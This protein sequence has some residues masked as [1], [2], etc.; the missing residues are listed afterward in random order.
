M[1]EERIDRIFQ[2]VAKS[3]SFERRFFKKLSETDNPYPWFEQLS[4]R[5]YLQPCNNRNPETTESNQYVVPYWQVLGY[6]ENAAKHLNSEPNDE[7]ASKLVDVINSILEYKDGNGNRIENPHTDWMIIK[8]VFKLP[9]KYVT[10]KQVK[11]IETAIESKWSNIT[12]ISA[13]IEQTVFP[14]LIRNDHGKFLLELLRIVIR[15]QKKRAGSLFHK[16]SII[17]EYWFSEAMKKNREDIVRICGLEAAKVT[18]NQIEAILEESDSYFS[19]ASIPAIEDN[20]QTMFPDEYECQL[21]YLV[22]DVLEQTSPDL[23]KD[24]LNELLVSQ[25]AIL[26]RIGIHTINNHYQTFSPLFWSWRGNPLEE[27][28]LIHEIFE[29][30]ESRFKY[31]SD[32][33]FTKLI[34]WIESLSYK[35][36]NTSHKDPEEVKRFEARARRRWLTAVLNSKKT[37]IRQLYEKYTQIDDTRIEH[38]SFLVWSSGVVIST[39]EVKPFPKEV[40]DLPN[41]QIADYIIGYEEPEDKKPFELYGT[42]A[43]SFGHIVPEYSGK[44]TQDMTP[45]LRMPFEYQNALLSGI[46]DSWN[47]GKTL[48]WKELL[49]YMLDLLSKKE[50]WMEKNKPGSSYRRDIICRISDLIFNGTN[51]DKHAFDAEYLALSEKILL[52]LGE[53]TKSEVEED[54]QDKI[55]AVLN[56]PLGRV[57]LAMMSYSLRFARIFKKDTNEKWAPNI[58]EHFEKILKSGRTVEFDVSL[59][60]F[61]SSL[62]FLDKV[63]VEENIDQIFPKDKKET[64]VRGFSSYLFY[65]SHLSKDLYCLLREKQ[66]YQIALATKLEQSA[67]M[68][69]SQIICSAYLNDLELL[70]GGSLLCELIENENVECL[71]DLILFVWRL[72]NQLTADQKKK[73]KPL[74]KNIIEFITSQGCSPEYNHALAH[75]SYWLA[76]VDKMDGEIFEWIQ[77][78]SRYIDDLSEIFFTEYLLQHVVKTPEFVGRIVFA[79]ANE[80]NYFLKFKKEQIVEIVEKLYDLQ[81]IEI[82]N[83]ICNLYLDG[84]YDF[85]R[86]T[87]EEHNRLPGT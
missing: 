80:R 40:L 54:V 34:W 56:A 13:E 77:I 32:E 69:L 15:P 87:W 4:K 21:V 53:K 52:F 67:G 37:E 82:A 2:N 85:L 19:I 33:Q 41:Q 26:K 12:L 36:S 42:L 45:F 1:M 18:I 57:Y 9:F 46:L 59:G 64:W 8:T 83:R 44:F 60:R 48:S 30:L 38:P 68:K 62:T 23:E 6:L 16:T 43:D 24:L 10:E 39:G 73:I 49:G 35:V 86:K 50:F 55:Q 20:P 22:R 27:I 65:T 76:L 51:D 25:Y 81:Q 17:D 70:S 58:R 63:W 14:F 72:R 74:W 75:L 11:F 66:H 31:F 28:D 47:T 61:L 79:I 84:G 29:L 7:I 5:N 78:S 71:T 3:P